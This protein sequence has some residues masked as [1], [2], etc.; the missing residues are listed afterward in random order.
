MSLTAIATLF[1]NPL[2]FKKSGNKQQIPRGHAPNPAMNTHEKYGYRTLLVIK[3]LVLSAM[4]SVMIM[5]YTHW[6]QLQ[7]RRELIRHSPFGETFAI[8]TMIFL[9]INVMA[10]IWRLVLVIMYRPSP[11]ISNSRLPVCTVIVPAYN[12]GSQVLRT[13]NSIAANDYP[14]D[15]LNIIAIDDGSVDDTWAWIEKAKKMLGSRLKTIRIPR[16]RGKRH[17]LYEGFK[18][19]RGEV[20][21]TVDSDSIIDPWTL[22][23]MASPFVDNPELGAVAGNVRVLNRVKGLIPKML[24]VSFLFSFDFLR[25]S[26]SMV[27]TVMCTPG[28]LSAYRR[29]IV[30]DVLPI[31]LNQKFFGKPANIGEDRA[32][33]NLILKA[34]YAVHYQGNA[35]VYTNVPT[36]YKNLCKM[37]IRWARSNIRETLV[38]S[39]FIFTRFRKKSMTGA[40]INFLLQSITMV[41]MPFFITCS[42]TCLILR[43]LESILVM[44][45]GTLIYSTLSAL[46]YYW[47][48]RNT[49][50]LWAYAYGF[51]WLVGLFWIT[52]YALATPHRSGWL[53]R[54]PK[55]KG[56]YYKQQ[57][58]GQHILPAVVP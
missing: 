33:T 55:I 3:I 8:L 21:V 44:M 16:N 51:F 4:V 13:L 45:M 2:S 58:H 31:W 19:S 11:V 6:E 57:E 20:I 53:T 18:K 42:L 38:M 47:R 49:E 46:F 22:R 48:Y 28:A 34:G 56:H 27:D 39:T 10:L 43:P 14:E 26:Q 9:G 17:A 54:Q 12:E 29:N 36:G 40:R 30:M 41:K 15:K 7:L 1:V 52:L 23:C 5:V 24:D 32:M 25:A 50:A 37:F 35:T